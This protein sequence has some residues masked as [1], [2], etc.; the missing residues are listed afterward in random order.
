MEAL[1]V[2]LVEV[3]ILAAT[4]CYTLLGALAMALV[5][6][7]GLVI[8]LLFH[9]AHAA[10]K[11]SERPSP[12]AP[13]PAPSRQGKWRWRHLLLAPFA[14]VLLAG[15]AVNLFFLDPA[16]RWLFDRFAGR[17]GLTVEFAAVEGNLLVGRLGFQGLGVARPEGEKAGFDLTAAAV[18]FDLDISSLALRPVRFERVAL[19][20]IAGTVAKPARR[21]EPDRITPRA[22]FVIDE[23]SVRDA[24]VRVTGA[25]GERF[26]FAVASAESRPLRSE[27]GV[28]DFF[29][30]SNVDARIDGHPF[31]IATGLT[32]SGRITTWDITD[33]P[34]NSV[35]GV[36]P[37]APFTWFEGGTI[38]ARVH[39]R[40]A[41]DGAATRIDMEWSIILDG[42]SVA[43][44]EGASTIE[45]VT[46]GALAKVANGREEPVDLAFT[47]SFDE[48]QFRNGASLDA[49]DFW[50][51]L[52]AGLGQ[53]TGAPEGAGDQE[54]PGLA[55][56]LRDALQRRQNSTED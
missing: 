46:A 1:I 23:L 24:Q 47:L 42:V 14:L 34:A 18:D 17:A 25:D 15:L 38:D 22:R 55:E 20:G 10:A 51:A 44:P 7:V 11:A 26:D 5:D 54:G 53:A 21:A 37:R 41:I 27:F 19:A 32:P 45:R 6:L 29:F 4:L 2:L 31:R 33:F 43:P 9:G 39:D 35:A 28:F 16:A 49:A 40:W 3:A 13:A 30:R 36:V 8:G 48:E 12:P 50:R 56:R 52:I